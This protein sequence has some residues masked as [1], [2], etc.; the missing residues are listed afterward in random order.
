MDTLKAGDVRFNVLSSELLCEH[1]YIPLFASTG[2]DSLLV[3]L[4][5]Y[6]PFGED[7]NL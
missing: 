4:V 5:H 3:I 7:R 6:G 2:T 1:I